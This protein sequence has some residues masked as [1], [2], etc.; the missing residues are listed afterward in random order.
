[1]TVQEITS[2]E[3]LEA[4][5]P[6]WE[7]LWR[8]C[9]A[10]TPFQSPQWLLPWWRNLFR[11]GWL[12]TLAARDDAGRLAGLAP[13]FI[14]FHDGNPEM[15]QVSFIGAGITDYLDFLGDAESTIH[16]LSH[17][18]QHAETWAIC[19]F[20]ELRPESPLLGAKF[21]ALPRLE[22]TKC[23]VCPVLSLPASMDELKARL[24]HHLKRS[25]AF[26][27][28]TARQETL[29]EFMDAL[30]RLHA[31]R[32]RMKDE[33]GMLATRR[34]R[35]FHREAAAEFLRAGMLRLHGMRRDGA[36]AA[37]IYAFADRGRTYAYLSGF[38]PALA[39]CSPGTLLLRFAIER[40]IAEGCSEFDFLRKKE[41]YKYLWG[42]RGRINRRIRM[43]SSPSARSLRAG[44]SAGC[45]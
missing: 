30:F 12:W 9:P 3:A 2:S 10:A 45:P 23:A 36:I 14:H 19:D 4:L 24:P 38:D 39:R 18:A 26:E 27:F 29:D 44:S 28:E 8:R 31:A 42:A 25:R 21:P 22:T 16:L 11:G 37:V 32:W 17:I 15:R 20:Q 1:M 43:I 13:L 5:R 40:A 7:E 33:E 34:L 6:E 35:N 41:D